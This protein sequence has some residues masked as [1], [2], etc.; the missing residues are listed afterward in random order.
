MIKELTGFVLPVIGIIFGCGVPIVIVWSVLYFKHRREALWHET[1]RLAIEKGQ[2]V[3]AMPDP[4][5]SGQP[6]PAADAAEWLRIRRQ[7]RRSKD[8]R[9]GLI[10]VAI[11]AAFFFA[12]H[13]GALSFGGAGLFPAYI[14]LGIGAAMLLNAMLGAM[15]TGKPTAKA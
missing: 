4:D 8:I 10:L 5:L 12:H 15:F 9:G 11:G 14:L 1:A 2:P 6:P 13:Q 3:P 7:A